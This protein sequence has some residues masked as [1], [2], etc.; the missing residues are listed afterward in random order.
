MQQGAETEGRRDRDGVSEPALA[1]D[2][3]RLSFFK[4]ASQLP[5]DGHGACGCRQRKGLHQMTS[6]TFSTS[7]ERRAAVF[8]ASSAQ[9]AIL[10]HRGVIVDTNT[11]WRLFAR[12]NGAAD[13]TTGV[14]VNYLEICEHQRGS[15]PVADSVADGLRAILSGERTQLQIEYPCHSLIGD[16]W[17]LLHAFAAPVDGGA[18]AV[19]HHIDVTARRLMAQGE[20]LNPSAGAQRLQSLLTG[21]GRSLVQVLLIE[22]TGLTEVVGRF[23]A[24][25]ADEVM[26]HLINRVRRVLRPDD[27]IF[28]VSA[29]SVGLGFHRLDRDPVTSIDRRLKNALGEPVQLG[30][31]QVTVG[32]SLGWASGGE[33][34]AAD[35]IDLAR[36]SLVDARVATAIVEASAPPSA[37]PDGPSVVGS[38][39]AAS[40]PT[41]SMVRSQTV[42]VLL[43][44]DNPGDASLMSS[45]LGSDS[46]GEDRLTVVAT[47]GDALRELNSKWFDCVLLD[48]GLPG[49]GGFEGLEVIHA[50][51]SEIPV[52]VLTSRDDTEMARSAVRE[53]AQDYLCTSD[54]T[55]R[56]LSQAIGLAVERSRAE[57]SER[58]MLM[59]LNRP[60]DL[61]LVVDPSGRL[62][63]ASPSIDRVLGL[64]GDEAIGKLLASL[65]RPEDRSAVAD[66]VHAAAGGSAQVVARLSHADGSWRWGEV[67]IEDW[68]ADAAIG[69][70]VLTVRDITERVDALAELRTEKATR[71]AIVTQSRDMVMFFRPDGEIVWTSPACRTLFGVGPEE[72]I[73]GN[74]MEM[75]HPDDLDRVVA[76][77]MSIPE[78]GDHVCV[79]FRVIDTEGN[80]RWIEELATNLVDDPLVGV[81]VGNLRDITARKNAEQLSEFKGTLLAAVGQPV[82][83]IDLENHVTFWNNAAE[84]TFGWSESEAM[85]KPMSELVP[86]WHGWQ[87]KADE[88]QPLQRSGQSWSGEFWVR[89]R[90]GDPVAIEV[91]STPVF[92]NG[93]QIGTVAVSTDLRERMEAAA[94]TAR[95]AL[96][97][98]T[99]SDAIYSWDVGGTITSWNRGAETLLGYTES[100]VVGRHVSVLFPED[101]AGQM[102][103]IVSAVLAGE[104]VTHDDTRR[105]ASDG[106]ELHV[107]LT[108]SPLRAQDG[109]IV[110]ASVIARDITERAELLQRLGDERR[111]LGDAQRSAHLG[112]FEIDLLTGEAHRS[113]EMLRILGI[114]PDDIGRGVDFQFVHPEDLPRVREVFDAALAGERDLEVTLRVVRPDGEIRWV[115][116]RSSVFEDPNGRFLSGTMLDITELHEARVELEQLAYFDTLTGLANRSMFTSQLTQVLAAAAA[117]DTHTAVGLVD[118]DRFKVVNDRL[119]HG[120][121]D[122]VLRAVAARFSAQLV[123]GDVIGRFGGD[124]FVVVRAASSAEEAM[125]L[126]M[127]LTASL[128]EPLVIGDRRFEMSASVGMVLVQPG[129]TVD[130]ALRD[131]DAAMYEAKAEGR[132][133]SVLMDDQLRSRVGRRLQLEEDLRSAIERDQMRVVFQ[134]VMDLESGVACGFESL[135]RWTHPELG[136][137]S[138]DEFISIAEETG[139]ILAIGE[140]VLEQ[141]LEQMATWRLQPEWSSLWVAV[142]LSGRQVVQADIVDRVV[143]LLA[144]AGLPSDAL[145]LEI[146]EGVL[147]D[148]VQQGID[149][150]GA[151]RDLGVSIKVDDFGTGYSSLS[152][153]KALPIDSL[154][155]DRSFIGGLG[156]DPHDTTIVRAILSIA[157][158]VGLS[159]VAEGVETAEQLAA[160]RALGC[161]QGQGY[162][163]SPG[164]DPETATQWLSSNA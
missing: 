70:L 43:V 88:I 75:I 158:T 157:S 163:W 35:L 140:W 41:R 91:T 31:V 131:A 3:V 150:L 56:Q 125:E 152:Y 79:E 5:I 46:D 104:S 128:A 111:R 40:E 90:S 11:A 153:L 59:L 155:I 37:E 60:A 71:E 154:K 67:T 108:A 30:T 122:E 145:H 50:A 143:A 74:G 77:F 13:E 144:A 9:S 14:G 39:T 96:I 55:Q 47:L 51:H 116:S 123:E 81:I 87:G 160:L 21:D 112:N 7:A 146:T 159:V 54:I 48:L 126:G 119:G 109:S 4:T 100:Q 134:P 99:S 164:V 142:N 94:T 73:G 118:L 28:Q 124:E 120:A 49:E 115:V 45:Q 72:L 16:R 1:V 129:G 26:A 27:A 53:G 110:G 15:D 114:G 113:E 17:Y 19:V 97:V 76:Q 86:P 10:D 162:L 135:L 44:E 85:G 83:A 57:M 38:D 103:Q 62:S 33:P 93:E 12:L 58:R 127:S 98:Q 32:H 102:E 8:D 156:S 117:T 92:D 2:V 130:D 24:P 89:D 107:S 148:A 133:R 149:T 139:S 22:F 106:R 138:P 18:G 20:M 25:A 101:L 121:G 36:A 141:S 151:L 161:P 80:V 137:V 147:V 95:L 63:Y 23:G 66:A 65:V 84:L 132:S 68:S 52:V 6:T 42:D 82:V 78:L 105:V 29:H 136:Q 34:D 61:V 69:G 64:S